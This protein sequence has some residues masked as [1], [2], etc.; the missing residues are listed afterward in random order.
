M[1]FQAAVYSVAMPL[2]SMGTYAKMS[3]HRNNPDH[4]WIK[5]AYL[6]FIFPG[7]T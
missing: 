6:L 2:V 7:G 1:E 4:L 3:G 5:V